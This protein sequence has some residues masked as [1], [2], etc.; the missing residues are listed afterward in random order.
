MGTVLEVWNVIKH[1]LFV[2]KKTGI[3]TTFISSATKGGMRAQMK[4]GLACWDRD[5]A[6]NFGAKLGEMGIER[7]HTRYGNQ[8]LVVPL[9]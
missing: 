3:D 1:L 5:V 6:R 4:R 7:V 2:Y 9:V 8:Y